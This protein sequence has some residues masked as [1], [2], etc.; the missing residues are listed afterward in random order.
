MKKS[1]LILT[2]ILFLSTYFTKAQVASYT[3]YSSTGYDYKFGVEYQNNLGVYKDLYQ[4]WDSMS[5]IFYFDTIRFAP[6]TRF[7]LP[8]SNSQYVG[9][10]GSLISFPTNL[11]SFTNGPAYI[12]QAGARTAISVTTTGSGG[13]TYNN[14]T[15]VLNVPNNSAT[16]I[17]APY[18][19]VT[20]SAAQTITANTLTTVTW[21]AESFKSG[22]THSNSTNNSRITLD[23]AGNY[24]GGVTLW[25]TTWN[26]VTVSRCEVQLFKNGSFYKELYDFSMLSSDSP[27]ISLPFTIT[28]GSASDYYE[29]KFLQNSGASRDISTTSFFWIKKI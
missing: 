28:N 11:S 24:S 8:G 23:E 2:S 3:N 27:S 21:G 7:I 5:L 18:I 20:K 12:N 1:I 15:G 14:S 4:M 6:G 26:S 22:I 16:Y 29:I 9:G 25:I 13:A 17:S 10:D 19:E